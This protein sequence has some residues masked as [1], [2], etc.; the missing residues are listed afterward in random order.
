[1]W[2]RGRFGLSSTL[3]NG[4]QCP[5]VFHTSNKCVEHQ[6]TATSNSKRTRSGLFLK[7]ITYACFWNT[8]PVE[9]VYLY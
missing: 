7:P 6:L 2:K 8:T 9:V 5:M 1:M 4:R 3:Y